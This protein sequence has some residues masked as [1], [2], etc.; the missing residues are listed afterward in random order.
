MLFASGKTNKR[1]AQELVRASAACLL[2]V[3][4]W[5]LCGRCAW[6]LVSTFGVLGGGLSLGAA[7]CL[8][9][10]ASKASGSGGDH[11]ARAGF[12][13]MCGLLEEYSIAGYPMLRAVG[14][15]ILGGALLMP[16]SAGKK[17]PVLLA[18]GVVLRAAALL[19]KC[20]SY[21]LP[22]YLSTLSAAAVFVYSARRIG[23]TEGVPAAAAGAAAGCLISVLTG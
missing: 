21:S 1:T 20:S 15:G 18:G 2:A 4:S 3:S 10:I 8:G 5:H 9:G 16:E 7:V 13:A 6:E 19:I 22:L 23:E 11:A 14:N 17:R 12:F